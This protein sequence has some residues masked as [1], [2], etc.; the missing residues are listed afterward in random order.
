MEQKKYIPLTVE[1]KDQS[2][3]CAYENKDICREIN[4]DCR[5]CKVFYSI[6]SMLNT[7]EKIYIT[8]DEEI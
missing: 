5:N 8:E 6:V 7:F 3:A 2:A 1:K 4:H